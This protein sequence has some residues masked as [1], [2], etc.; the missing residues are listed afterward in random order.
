MGKVNVSEIFSPATFVFLNQNKNT[1]DK[2]E[3]LV[4]AEQESVA[5]PCFSVDRREDAQGDG[6]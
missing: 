6:I 1:S 5:C 3:G 4:K 2:K